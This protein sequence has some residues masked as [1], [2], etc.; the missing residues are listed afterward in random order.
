M[1]IFVP[2][3]Y[4]FFCYFRVLFLYTFLVSFGKFQDGDLFCGLCLIRFFFY[5]SGKA[6]LEYNAALAFDNSCLGI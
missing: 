2:V 1:F 3:F 6:V 5:K 4:I